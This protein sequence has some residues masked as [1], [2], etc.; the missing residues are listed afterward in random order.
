MGS[1][2]QSGVAGEEPFKECILCGNKDNQK[3]RYATW[4]TTERMYLEKHFGM[5]PQDNTFICKKHLVEARRH[6]HKYDHVPSWKTSPSSVQEF[7]KQQCSNPQCNNVEY[8]KLIKPLFASH[9]QLTELFEIEHTGEPFVLCRKCYNETY[10]TIC[11]TGSTPCSSCGAK[12]KK[13]T[14]FCRHSPDAEKVSQHLSNQT[15]QSMIIN[16]NDYLC[17]TCYKT[18]CLII[19][20]LKSPHGSDATLKQAIDQWVNKYNNEN[21][22]TLTKAIL[23]TVIY[24]A[25]NLLL[26]KAV[27][28]PWA[29]K[30]FLQSYAEYGYTSCI[31]SAKVTIETRDSSVMFSGKWLLHQLIE[32]LNS[33]MKVKMCHSVVNFFHTYY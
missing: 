8:D 5:S 22:D 19:E 32:Y 1:Q 11:G 29:C 4:G 18:H 6:G 28:L 17:S 23:E 13:G 31:T 30:V 24:I 12:P 9:D 21:I 20:S 10:A 26:E 33:Y 3:S 25:N 16:P 2:L 7:N 27:L 14:A 15:G